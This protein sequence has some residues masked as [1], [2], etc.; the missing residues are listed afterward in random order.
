MR[1]RRSLGYEFATE[2]EARDSAA[3]LDRRFSAEELAGLRVYRIRWSGNYLV[4]AVFPEGVSERRLEDARALLGSWGARCTPRIWRTT[5][6]RPGRAS[7]CRAGS[8]AFSVSDPLLHPLL[9]A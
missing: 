8:D 9:Q 7:S 6:G 4:E 1:G 2:R 5:S 3:E